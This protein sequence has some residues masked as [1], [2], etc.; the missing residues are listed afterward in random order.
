MDHFD[1][2]L[3]SIQACRFDEDRIFLEE[4]LR[5]YPENAAPIYN[6]ACSTLI[7][8]NLKEQ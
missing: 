3:E 6:L 2:A 5:Q 1:L 8:A 7:W 4:L